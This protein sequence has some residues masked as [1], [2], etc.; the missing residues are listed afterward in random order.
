MIEITTNPLLF[1]PI[2]TIIGLCVGSFLNV[3]IYRLPLMLTDEQQTKMNLCYPSSNCPHCK[4]PIAWHHNIPL[5]SYLILKGRCP[6]CEQPIAKTYPMVELLTVMCSCLVAWHFGF[7]I[8]LLFALIFTWFLIALTVIDL[9]HQL[10]PDNLTLPL[11]WLGLLVNTQHIF[12]PLPTAVFG[13]IVGYSCLWLIYW[14]FKLA[15]GKEGLG[16][17]DFKLL[18][19]LGAWVG[20]VQLSLILLIA[21]LMGALIGISLMVFYNHPRDKPIPFGP[22]LCLAGFICLLY[23]ESLLSIFW[24]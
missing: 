14:L 3:V 17:G 1:Y 19:A 20:W 13:A 11:I 12:V 4:H 16:Y 18:A 24:S 21:S 6:Y 8:A 23:G 22:F 5:F 9:Q 15:T 10:L 2:I 7:G